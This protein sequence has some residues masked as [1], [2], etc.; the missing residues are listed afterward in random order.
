M[1]N[2]TTQF[3]EEGMFSRELNDGEL[4]K[5]GEG[6]SRQ[7]EDQVQK[8]RD[9]YKLGKELGEGQKDRNTQQ[10]GA[11]QREVDPYLSGPFNSVWDCHASCLWS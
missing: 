2:T 3:Q 7:S 4:A 8:P 5:S 9:G 11:G 10:A 1:E 6:Q